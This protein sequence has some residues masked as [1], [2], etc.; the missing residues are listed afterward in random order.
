MQRASLSERL[1]RLSRQEGECLTFTGSLNHRGYGL[2]SHARRT[3]AA[4]R[5]AYEL[6]KGKIPDGLVIDHLCRNRACVNPDHLEPVT[7]KENTRRGMLGEAARARA[8][9]QTHCRNG[10]PYSEGSTYNYGGVRYCKACKKATYRRQADKRPLKWR[11]LTD[12]QMA[13]VFR[14]AENGVSVEDIA[15]AV[16]RSK[17]WVSS[18]LMANVKIP[19]ADE[20]ER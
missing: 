14:Q 20:G 12:E 6:A 2:F 13:L 5:V 10:H 9:A 17:S 8:A 11:K 16:G 18:L 19:A 3:R 15:A 7:Q 4:H 1:A